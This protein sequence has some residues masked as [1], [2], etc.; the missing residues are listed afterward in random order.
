[1]ADPLAVNITQQN[2]MDYWAKT[3]VMPAQ[4]FQQAQTNP[5]L[6]RMLTTPQPGQQPLITTWWGWSTGRMAATDAWCAGIRRTWHCQ[7][8]EGQH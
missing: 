2:L 1:V 4:A 3:G 5:D 6:K 7:V 8:L